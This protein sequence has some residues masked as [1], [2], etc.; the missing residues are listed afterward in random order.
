MLASSTPGS[1]QQ[2][3]AAGAL[4]TFTQQR[5]GCLQLLA[6][7][8]VPAFATLVRQHVLSTDANS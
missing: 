8:G 3:A 2:I 6:A 4:L 5:T 7:G 1:D